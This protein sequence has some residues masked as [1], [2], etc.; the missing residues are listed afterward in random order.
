MNEGGSLQILTSKSGV[1]ALQEHVLDALE[2]VTIAAPE[3]Q[4]VLTYDAATSQ[5]VN[6]PSAGG[7]STGHGPHPAL[8]GRITGKSV[9]NT[10]AI[11]LFPEYPSLAVAWVTTA[12]QLQGDPTATIP[13]STWTIA[14]GVLKAGEAG[15]AVNHYDFFIQVPVWM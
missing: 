7:G 11:T 14:A 13:A 10:Y 9:D 3:D 12:T 2:D 5:W 4:Q 8:V 6:K 1:T 15:T